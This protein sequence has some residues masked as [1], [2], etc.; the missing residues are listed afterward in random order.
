MK[1]FVIALLAVFA[2]NVAI[3]SQSHAAAS[4]ATGVVYSLTNCAVDGVNWTPVFP[5]L[6]KAI[7]AITVVNNS[8]YPFELGIG[9]ANSASAG[10]TRQLV[11]KAATSPLSMDLF[12][13]AVGSVTR[14]SIRSLNSAGFVCTGSLQIN[15]IYN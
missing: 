9:L 3:P 13:L 1:H 12:P 2:L 4:S 14:I 6:V 7:K 15:A 5:S 11:L 10:D 8:A